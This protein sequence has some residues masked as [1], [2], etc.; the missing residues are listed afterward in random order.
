M[1]ARQDSLV[2]QESTP[3]S[4]ALWRNRDYVG[5]WVGETVSGFGTALSAFAYPLLILTVTGS[6]A[7]AG[8]VG[9]TVSIGALTTMLVGGSLADRHS[10]RMLLLAGSLLQ[11]VAVGSVCWAV[12]FDHVNVAYVAAIGLF[13]GFAG[14]LTS[15]ASRPALRRIVP[16]KQLPAAFSQM[17]GRD[18]AVRLAAP[19]TGGFLFSLARWVPFLGDAVSFLVSALG[20]LLIRQPLGPDVREARREPVVASIRMGLAY[21]RRDAYLRFL[22]IYTATF[23][24]AVAGMFLLVIVLVR[25]HGGG[26]ML[27]G[28]VNSIGAVGGLA[29]AVFAGRVTRRFH[30]RAIV[31]LLSWVTVVVFAAIG[32]VPLP[33]LIGVLVA[34]LLF[35]VSPINVIFATYETRM[36]PD[37]LMGRVSSAIDSGASSLRWL[38]PLSAGILSS[39]FGPTTA[40]LLLTAVVALVAV[41]TQV[42]R[43]LR[44]LDVPIGDVRPGSI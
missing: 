30:G 13:Q 35:L 9:S 42:A 36:I 8:I 6:A 34:V 1:T 38:G 26:P 24:A 27:V 32:V 41:G 40:M 15:G 29:G 44:V 33:W 43:G 23:N 22:T 4:K 2:N 17:Q 16:P 31:I 14:G 28:W 5:W 37:E 25:G 21:I 39:A 10:R 12:A 18:M 3:P 11:A 20:V 7:S 19:P